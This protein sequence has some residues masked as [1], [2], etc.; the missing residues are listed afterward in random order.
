M[1]CDDFIDFTDF[2]QSIAER[3]A[4][5]EPILVNSADKRRHSLAI[6]QKN[7]FDD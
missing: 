7:S 4:S 5:N 2:A 3:I 1:M 6:Y